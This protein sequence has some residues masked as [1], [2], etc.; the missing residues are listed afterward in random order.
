MSSETLL[1]PRIISPPTMRSF[2]IPTPPS[3]WTEPVVVDV[4]SVVSS[5]ERMPPT[6]P[7]PDTPSEVR[8]PTEVM[9][10]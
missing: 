4:V 10:D 6:V 5:T 1:V 3:V 9:A 2:A 8:V 7:V